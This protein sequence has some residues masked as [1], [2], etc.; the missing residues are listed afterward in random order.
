MCLELTR[1]NLGLDLD[2]V[3]IYMIYDQIIN[4]LAIL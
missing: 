1:S 4:Y 2:L 3:L